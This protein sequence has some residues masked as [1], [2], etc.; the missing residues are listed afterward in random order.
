MKALLR[1]V[2]FL[3]LVW[4][5]QRPKEVSS[6]DRPR[7]YQRAAARAAFLQSQSIGGRLVAD[8]QFGDVQ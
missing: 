8:R 3:R 5:Q 1:W 6:V 2:A 4:G 7:A